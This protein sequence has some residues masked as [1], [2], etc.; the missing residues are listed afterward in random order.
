[1]LLTTYFQEDKRERE[2]HDKDDSYAHA[3]AGPATPSCCGARWG[4]NVYRSDDRAHAR[5][6]RAIMRLGAFVIPQFFAIPLV[7]LVVKVHHV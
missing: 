6:V 1:M 4:L 2:H 5:P 3:F 7:D